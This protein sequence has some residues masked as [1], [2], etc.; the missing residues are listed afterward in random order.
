M[1]LIIQRNNMKTITLLLFLFLSIFTFP[2]E[3]IET[4]KITATNDTTAVGTE[5]RHKHF[6]LG[7]HGS[8]IG[9]G[10]SEYHNGIRFNYRDCGVKEVNGINFT[11]WEGYQNTLHDFSMNGISIGTFPVAGSM[12][13]ITLGLAGAISMRDM[14]GVNIGGLALLSHKG[15]ITGINVSSLA[16]VSVGGGITG[17]NFGGLALVSPGGDITGINF[18]GLAVVSPGGSIIGVNIS[19]LAL[20]SPK[21]S[22]TGIN[23]SGLAIV[24]PGG[25]ITGLN[26]SGLALV[27]P[28]GDITGINFS[29]LALVSPD[30]DITGI[31]TTLGEI[32]CRGNLTGINVAG[33]KI[34]ADRITGLTVAPIWIDTESLTG[35][36]LTGYCR[37]NGTQTGVSIALVNDADYLNGL[38]I[39]LLN[40]ARQNSGLSIL[41]F[42]NLHLGL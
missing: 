12:N 2:Q 21:G 6:T 39:G 25:D 1:L 38:Q 15:T 31:N 33:Y 19:T 32:H 24:A 36:T 26:I 9:F 34:K 29:G 17:F 14:T 18:G 3:K 4:I 5:C 16:I 13:G 41:P 22:I 28:G 10:N 23:F 35:L 20:V 27:S 40:I 30:G 37:V 11:L 8:G 7:S 42:I